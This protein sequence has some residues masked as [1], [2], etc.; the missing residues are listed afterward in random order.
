MMNDPTGRI[1]MAIL[2]TNRVCST[3]QP[4]ASKET[5]RIVKSGPLLFM[6]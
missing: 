6:G 2:I 1:R 5:A 4:R 3:H